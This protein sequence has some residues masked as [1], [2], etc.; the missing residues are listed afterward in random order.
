MTV[1]AYAQAKQF[2]SRQAEKLIRFE[3]M[4]FFISIHRDFYPE[5]DVT[6]MEHFL[7]IAEREGEFV[8][9]HDALREY[10]VMTSIDSSKVHEKLATLG[11]SEGTDYRVAD[12]REPVAQG[13]Y[14]FSKHYHLTPEAFKTCLMRAQRRGNQPVDPVIYVKYYLLLEKIFGLYRDYQAAYQERLLSMKDDRIDRLL[15]K[16]DD[17]TSTIERLESMALTQTN[18]M[19]KLMGYAEDTNNKLEELSVKF[20]T[21]FDFTSTFARSMLSTWLG[22]FVFR[23]QVDQLLQDRDLAYALNHLKVMF[24]VA[25][26]RISE[27]KMEFV[28]YFCCTNFTDVGKRIRDLHKRHEEMVMLKPEA[29]CLISQE[30]NCERA[31]LHQ[32]AFNNDEDVS[33][34]NRRKAFHVTMESTNIDAIQQKYDEIVTAVR[35]EN[36]QG[37]QMRRNQILS[38]DCDV[39][40]NIIRQMMK[41]DASFFSSSLPRCQE[42]IDCATT[43]DAEGYK[44]VL[45]CRRTTHREDLN[46]R[47]TDTMYALRKLNELLGDDGDVNEIEKMIR[48]GV[49]TKHDLKSLMKLSKAVA[50]AENVALSKIEQ[51]QVAEVEA[52]PE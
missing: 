27:E 44:P 33:Y 5:I 21:L 40:A 45:V 41:S 22:G 12:V 42:Y 10:G 47:M 32:L 14:S 50:K 36:F 46:E 52:L 25:F 38:E 3:L 37:Y 51:E 48:E 11:L 17:Q 28:V 23:T 49:V 20:D 30:I 43:R 4:E 1:S 16:V 18:K 13:G 34:N 15:K 2:A 7:S 24:T 39:N 26:Y 6:F 19:D 9:H 29:I 35:K 8:V 31:K